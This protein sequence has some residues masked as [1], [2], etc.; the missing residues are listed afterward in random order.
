MRNVQDNHDE[1]QKTLKTE[2]GDTKSGINSMFIDW[3]N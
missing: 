1:Y 2:T 3:D